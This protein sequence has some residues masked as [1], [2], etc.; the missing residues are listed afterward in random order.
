G[1]D[2]VVSRAAGTR[3]AGGPA[4]VNGAVSANADSGM[5]GGGGTMDSGCPCSPFCICICDARPGDAG[6]GD[7]LVQAGV[8]GAGG[9]GGPFKASGCESGVSG[10]NGLPG[11]VADGKGGAAGNGQPAAA[12]LRGGGV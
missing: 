1:A 9:D 7:T 8:Y 10:A 2:L 3:G 4:G 12:P 11:R 6:S 5:G